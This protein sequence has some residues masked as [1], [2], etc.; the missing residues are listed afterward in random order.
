M[1]I[2]EYLYA[3]EKR[4]N[5]YVDQIKSPITYDKVP[6]WSASLTALV[7]K[8]T[9]TQARHGREL[10]RHEKIISL[11]KY[12]KKKKLVAMSREQIIKTD[13]L[14]FAIET[15][16]ARRVRIPP[17]I[18]EDSEALFIWLSPHKTK[19]CIDGWLCLIEDFRHSDPEQVER[20]ISG[21][22]LFHDLL[23]T[24]RE[25]KIDDSVKDSLPNNAHSRYFDLEGKFFKDPVKMLR[26]AGC[27]D[28]P[29]RMIKC[30]YRIRSWGEEEINDGEYY[31]NIFGYP[32]FIEDALTI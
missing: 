21:F 12:L 11:E 27:K 26:D 10:T 13:D 22:S 30:L 16:N 5:S 24:I 7:P 17:K 29:P 2:A 14:V 31:N 32:I 3:D 23:D 8:V 6:I 28:W 15:F 4:I 1:S 18:K 20:D 25:A 9:A 19:N